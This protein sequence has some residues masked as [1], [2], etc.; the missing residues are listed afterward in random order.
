MEQKRNGFQRIIT[1]DESWS[2]FYDLPGSICVASR[3]EFLQRIK[4]KMDTVKYLVSILRSVNRIHGLLGV[5]KGTL[6][7]VA[8]FTDA[9]MPCLIENIWLRTCRNTQK[10]LQ[11]YQ[12]PS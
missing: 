4:Q 10:S 6:Y 7:N 3:D 9:V 8:F 2:F 12:I 11:G 1:G 5:P